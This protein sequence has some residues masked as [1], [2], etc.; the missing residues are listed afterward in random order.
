MHDA[1]F[2]AWR[3]LFIGSRKMSLKFTR[4]VFL[5]F[6]AACIPA[7]N[8]ANLQNPASAYCEDQ[9]YTLEIRTAADGSQSG[10]CVFPD[11]SACDEWAYFR[12][13][14]GPGGLTLTSTPQETDGWNVYRNVELGYSFAY[15]EGLEIIA[16]DDPTGSLIIS[17]AGLGDGAWSISH[18]AGREEFRPPEGTNL[19]EW[20]TSHSMLGEKRM[21]DEQIA[22]TTAIH[23]RHERSPQSYADD[24]YYFMHGTQLFLV[25][26]SHGEVEDLD[27]SARFLQS[28]KFE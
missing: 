3:M 4:I 27:R 22:G 12:G 6:L 16:G 1:L 5:L 2:L 19:E 14:C 7:R 9:G 17:G 10:V 23:F 24:R 11:G 15:P 28:I 8:A 25:I 21:P 18:P 13:A 20:L 26:V